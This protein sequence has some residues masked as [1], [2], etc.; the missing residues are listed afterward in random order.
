VEVG[1]YSEGPQ[2]YVLEVKVDDKRVATFEDHED[3]TIVEQA[4]EFAIR[5]ARRLASRDMCARQA[6]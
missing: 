4:R 2:H 1:P 5:H 6:S 3:E